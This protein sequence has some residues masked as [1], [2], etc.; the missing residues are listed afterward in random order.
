MQK[1]K[2]IKVNFFMNALLTMSSVVFPLIT[3]SHVARVLGPNGTGIVDFVYPMVMYFSM[4]AQ[5]GIPTYGIRVCAKV[6]DDKVELS[7]VV[8][9]LLIINMITCALAYICFFAAIALVPQMQE[10]KTLFYILGSLILLNTIGVEWLYKGLEEYSYITIRSLIFKVIVLI[11]IVTMIQK[12]SDYVLYGALFIMAQVGSNI[13][14]FLHLH[15]IIIIKPVGGYHFKR[16]LKPIMSFFAMSI[17]TT[18]Y[19]SVDTT[20]IR[21]MKG[22]AENSFYSQSVKI[23]TAL[24][25]VVTALGAVLLPRASYYLEKGLEDEFLR[26][27]RKASILFLFGDQYTRSIT[28]MQLIMPTVF[29]IGLSNILGIQMLIPMGRENVVVVSEIVGAVVDVII[30]ALLIPKYGASGA[31][32]GTVTAEFAVLA[33]Q[34]IALKTTVLPLV[35]QIPVWKHVLAAVVSSIPCIAIVGIG[36]GNFVTLMVS[37]VLFFGIYLIVLILLK[38]PFIREYVP[39]VTKFLSRKK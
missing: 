5:L 22:Y 21:F 33:V 13:V 32:I 38:E 35:R 23:K 34:A 1:Q 29:A 17:A 39:M 15:K 18:I 30:N 37:A 24:V 28:A 6:R 36:L 14:N 11:C 27:S 8:Q 20:M 26:I 10:Q 19:T 3:S 16:H 25:N 9:E 7:R 4:I 31:A 2:S 12:E